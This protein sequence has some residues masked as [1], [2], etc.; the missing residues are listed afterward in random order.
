LVKIAR[1]LRRYACCDLWNA[2]PSLFLNSTCATHSPNQPKAKHSRLRELKQDWTEEEETGPE[3]ESGVSSAP[4]EL[5]ERNLAE[6]SEEDTVTDQDEAEAEANAEESVPANGET[7]E[8]H[9]EGAQSAEVIE[10]TE[11]PLPVATPNGV[12]QY[13][14]AHAS[15]A[16]ANTS[17]ATMAV[18]A[19]STPPANA[20][21]NRRSANGLA[22]ANYQGGSPVP[23][24]KDI[25]DLLNMP[26]SQAAAE[27]GIPMSTL[28][29]RWKE[30]VR[31]RK[32]PYR[33]V[34]KL[35]KEIMTLLHNIPARP[36]G[37]AAAAPTP[38]EIEQ[39]LGVLLRRRQE[40]LRPVQIR[41]N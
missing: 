36:E 19:P 30:A 27:L 4:R 21:A 29:K 13:D 11:A 20:V 22:I 6:A 16:L 37:D 40:E 23:V 2:H 12:P 9:P 5:A 7:D 3:E 8:E 34:A 1:T 32:W 35:D 33:Q 10:E 39:A 15:S 14:A 24:Y 25:T 26:Q 31:I 28:S 18:A 38:P 41:M 17:N